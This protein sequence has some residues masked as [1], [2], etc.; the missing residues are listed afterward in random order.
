MSIEIIK[1]GV[2]STL[3]DGGRKG[4][5]STGIGP[6]GAMDLFAMAVSNFLVGN[7][8]TAAVLE[9]NFPAPEILFLQNALISLTGADLSASVNN[10]PLPLWRPFFVKKDSLLKFKE[11][12][13]GAKVYLAVQGGWKSDKWLGSYSTHLKVAAGGHLGRALLKDDEVLFNENNFSL[14]GDKVL[15]WQLSYKQTDQVYQPSNSIRCVKSI[16]WGLLDKTSQQ[17]FEEK[18]FEISNQSDR[19]GYRLNG[20]LLSLQQPTEL[21]SSAVDAGT[22]QLLPDG[23]LI[24]LMADHQTTGGYPRIA[25]VIKADLPKLSQLRPGQPVNFKTVT[26]K[27]AEDVLISMMQL[28][29]EIKAGCHLNF[30]KYFQS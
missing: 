27:E 1:P 22:I 20:A 11:P 12:V 3:Q 14:T 18:E 19:M 21:I 4:F 16:E 28:L 9:I 10:E 30:E 17:N 8:E 29:T 26:V 5:R 25:S 24:V 13:H 15:N 6:G 2:L 23:H 7:E